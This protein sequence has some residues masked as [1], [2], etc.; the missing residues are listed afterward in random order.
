MRNSKKN[1]L[2]LSFIIWSGAILQAQ[3]GFDDGNGGVEGS[4]PIAASIDLQI[5]FL[6]FG[7]LIFAYYLFLHKNKDSKK[8]NS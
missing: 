5:I 7:A 1:N 3:P 8:E 4:D 2:V 6:L